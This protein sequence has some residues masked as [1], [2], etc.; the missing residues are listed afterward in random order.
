MQS[1][2]ADVPRSDRKRAP[3]SRRVGTTA[4]AVFVAAGAAGFL[5]DSVQTKS[6]EEAGYTLTLTY[7]R[8]SRSGLDVPWKLDIASTQPLPKQVVVAVT[9]EYFNIFEEQGLDPKPESQA[10]D[11]EMEY[12]T[13]NTAGGNDISISVDH[14]VEPG[15]M[16]GS[17]GTVGLYIDGELIAPLDFTTS[18]LP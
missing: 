18:M 12:W 14:Y 5:G 2:T 8:V 17:S 6:A 9:G 13:F 3:W 11:G 7:P 1:T 16:T 10:A 4:L 15:A